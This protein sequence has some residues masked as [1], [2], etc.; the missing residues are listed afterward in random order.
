M[1]QSVGFAPKTK[2]S[3]DKRVEEI[4]IYVAFVVGRRPTRPDK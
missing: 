1:A 4:R 3:L 2:P